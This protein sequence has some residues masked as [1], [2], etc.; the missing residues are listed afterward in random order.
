[1]S[2]YQTL[3]RQELSVTVVANLK[4]VVDK[5]EFTLQYFKRVLLDMTVS[6]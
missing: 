5:L 3:S 4:T 6:E 2:Q 1:M